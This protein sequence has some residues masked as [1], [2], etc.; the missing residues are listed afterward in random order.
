ML[1]LLFPPAELY[2]IF[3]HWTCDIVSQALFDENE[4]R[5]SVQNK[6]PGTVLPKT[7]IV[8]RQINPQNNPSV[9]KASRCPS[10]IRCS[11][12]SSS[13][14]IHKARSMWIIK[15]IY[16][17]VWM[18]W[19]CSLEQYIHLPFFYVRAPLSLMYWRDKKLIDFVLL[20]LFYDVT[21]ENKFHWYWVKRIMLPPR[22]FCP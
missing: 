16:V 3:W 20:L 15:M 6:I 10:W 21:Y 11:S 9:M 1:L 2:F 19:A 7:N 8:G 22:C 18:V 4:I 5:K 17:Q 14:F 12:A 13:W